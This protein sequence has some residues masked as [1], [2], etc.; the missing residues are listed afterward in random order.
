MLK[1]K[2]LAPV[3][4]INQEKI[5]QLEQ[6]IS[7]KKKSTETDSSKTKTIREMTIINHE[8]LR[9]NHYQVINPSEKQSSQEQLITS[10][11]G[12]Q[13]SQ[14][15]LENESLQSNIK[16]GTYEDKVE[17]SLNSQDHH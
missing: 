15:R 17:A 4:H 10:V 16:Q 5:S 14:P 9:H 7:E 12:T 3:K 2:F 11:S 1:Q 13:E 8:E 6:M